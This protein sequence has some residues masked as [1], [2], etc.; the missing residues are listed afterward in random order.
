MKA[1]FKHGRK[2]VMKEALLVWLIDH[3]KYFNCLPMEFEYKGRVFNYDEILNI[4]N[5]E[6]RA[7]LNRLGAMV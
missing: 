7:L 2:P 4:L 5:K 3:L 6:D 1:K